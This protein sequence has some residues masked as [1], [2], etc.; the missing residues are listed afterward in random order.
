MHFLKLSLSFLLIYIRI[1]SAAQSYSVSV[2]QIGLDKGLMKRE[3][4]CLFE[5]R[6]GLIWTGNKDGLQRYDG[7]EFKSWNK[8]DVHGKIAH[9]IA[10][11]QD[12]AG[13]LWLRNNDVKDFVFLHPYTNEI[14]TINERF[15][16]SLPLTKSELAGIYFNYYRRNFFT[17]SKQRLYFAADQLRK[18]IRY[19]T[20]KG[21]EV[22]S[23]GKGE[24]EFQFSFGG[25]LEEFR[26]FYIDSKDQLW[27]QYDSRHLAKMTQ[28]YQVISTYSFDT[29]VSFGQFFEYNEAIYFNADTYLDFKMGIHAE[30][31]T[32]YVIHGDSLIKSNY[33]STIPNECINNQY[34]VNDKGGWN[35]YNFDHSKLIITLSRF[36]YDRS[37]FDLVN[38]PHLD[39]KGG[40]WIF[41]E[42]GLNHVQIKENRFTNY[43]SFDNK[44]VKPFNNSTRGIR[45]NDKFVFANLEL[46][47][48]T[49]KIDKSFPEN[50]KIIDQSQEYP[51][52]LSLE[53]NTLLVGTRYNLREYNLNTQQIRTIPF[54]DPEYLP[55]LNVWCIIQDKNKRRWLG[56]TGGLAYHDE[57]GTN[58]HYFKPEDHDFGFTDSKS[59]IQYMKADSAGL[60]WLCTNKGLFVFDPVIKKIISR[61]DSQQSG[62]YYLPASLFYY[63]HFDKNGIRWLG[64]SE[65]LIRWD[66]YKKSHR[67]FTTKDRLANNVIY[68]VMEDKHD[69]LWLSSD[70]GIMQF[71]KNSFAINTFHVVDG[72]SHEEFNRT[73]HTMDAVGRIYF[74]GLNGIT[75]FQPEEFYEDKSFRVP[76]VVLTQINIYDGKLQ[77]LVDKTGEI[78]SS[79]TI[80][81]YPL[82][83]Y[84][85]LKC[86]LPT[87]ED[88]ASIHYAWKIT[89]I[90]Q[91]WNYQ[92]EN[93]IQI[94]RLPYGTHILELKG[95]SAHSQWSPNVLQYTIQVIKPFYLRAWF[96]SSLSV[97]ILGILYAIYRIRTAQLLKNQLELKA[98]IK[99]A[100]EKIEHDKNLIE[101]QAK[102]LLELDKQ[103][104]RF[105]A[106]VSHELR[107]PLT[108]MLGPIQSALKNGN[109]NDKTK[110]W[111]HTAL[112]GGHDL[113][114]LINSLLDLS[115]LEQ[116]KITVELSNVNI[117]NLTQKILHVF[118]FHAEEFNIDLISDFQIPVDTISSLDIGK[119][120]TILNNYLT[121][122]FKHTPSNGKIQLITSMNSGRIVFEVKD[123]G[124]GIHEIDK[125]HVFKRFYQ[126]NVPDAKTEGGAGIGL[127]I[128]YELAN[129]MDGSVWVKSEY[130]HGSSF[131]LSLPFLVKQNDYYSQQT[132][133]RISKENNTVTD[134][135][136]I[137]IKPNI[138]IVEDNSNLRRYLESI[139]SSKY[140]VFSSVHGQ[141]ALDIL[142]KQDLQNPNQSIHLILSDVMMPVMDG[143]KLLEILKSTP[144]Y[145]TIPVVMLTARADEQDRL[146]ALRIGVDDYILKP[147][148]EDVLLT[149]ID[150]LIQSHLVKMN[151]SKDEIRSSSEKQKPYALSI[152]DQEWLKVLEANILLHMGDSK[153]SV[154]TMAEY[155]HT[156]NRTF[157]RKLKAITGMTPGEYIKEI[158]LH[159]A[160]QFAE[161]GEYGSLSELAHKVGFTDP[162]YF[163]KLF[164]SRFGITIS[165][166]SK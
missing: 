125:D 61:F 33:Q 155:M 85:R 56:M 150:H 130:G 27:L 31:Y 15:G 113:L 53:N 12:D 163:A 87:Y 135:H 137:R 10:V 11:G 98:Q 38:A 148:E 112:S 43:F 23:F 78:Y 96:I 74:G 101:A 115:R 109:L 62:D 25:D 119:V 22:K 59:E 14:K 139:L 30:K 124:K 26:L 92:T 94:G 2:N 89:G 160:K 127:S 165:S 133:Q 3:V 121:N 134:K 17:D 75:S 84:L 60:I 52:A 104:S 90:D 46:S 99:K 136:E 81:L 103:K 144:S 131:Y 13:W 72:I 93:T 45:V 24:E 5:D 88:P 44:E 65:G 69:H 21:F 105:F 162:E 79:K 58:L 7:K 147:F 118:Q 57:G 141:D 82:D 76:N 152:Q 106:N 117:K 6:D 55:Y 54:T 151:W 107:T 166:K 156:S 123:N 111:L 1:T 67:L 158:R 70:F 4:Y 28:D 161:R 86:I 143:Y 29:D 159:A 83:Q 129:L 50:Y 128:C 149:S 68:A 48:T 20:E 47:K 157:N 142:S 95:Q 114:K 16:S 35:I 140:N 126:T 110:T 154:D 138:I 34:W 97:L 37:L 9:I 164:K 80:Y 64:T 18:I 108:L 77:K 36:D 146:R 39:K 66:N 71:D 102:D 91:D 49:V 145:H 41:G 8:N 122:A 51:R 120:E 63:I 19:S 73:S 100:T 42:F 153:F 132:E 40:I 32:N 116:N